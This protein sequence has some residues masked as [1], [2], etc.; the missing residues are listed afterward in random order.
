MERKARVT[1]DQIKRESGVLLSEYFQ[2]LS[3]VFKRCVRL[4]VE[5]SLIVIISYVLKDIKS[6]VM[7]IGVV[8]E[9]GLSDVNSAI[10]IPS[11]N[12]HD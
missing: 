11:S 2:L 6:P 10:T 3:D 7:N 12:L 8:L 1:L 9:G 4:H 5:F